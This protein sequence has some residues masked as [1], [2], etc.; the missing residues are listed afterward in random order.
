M[1]MDGSELIV[2]AQIEGDVSPGPCKITIEG[3]DGTTTP[4]WG[5][6]ADVGEWL[7]DGVLAVGNRVLTTQCDVMIPLPIGLYEVTVSRGVEYEAPSQAI[8]LT[9][10]EMG[11]VEPVLSRVVDS[12]GWACGDMHVHSGPSLDSDV[13]IDQRLVSAVAEGLDVLVPTDHDTRGEWSDPMV[14]VELDDRLGLAVGL[15]VSPD[16]WRNAFMVGHANAYPLPD[17]FQPSEFATPIPMAD[18]IDRL[19]PSLPDAVFQLNHPRLPTFAAFDFLGE[20]PIEGLIAHDDGT[21]RFQVLEVW[22]AHELDLGADVLAL[23]LADWYRLL[24]AGIHVVGV[25]N[26]DTHRLTFNMIGY[27]RTCARVADDRA[28]VDGE[29]FIDSVRLGHAFATSGPFV[30]VSI[31]DKSLFD[32]VDAGSPVRIDV[33][34]S[35]PSWAAANRVKL[36]QDGQVVDER[37]I[38]SLPGEASFEIAPVRDGWVIVLVEGPEPPSARVAG[39]HGPLRLPTFAFTN[40]IFLDVDGDGEIAP[41]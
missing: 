35:A 15:E 34:V 16:F 37:P 22:N 2:R 1:S 19:R 30:E 3:R 29:A 20:A 6:S 21:L 41:R 31:G 32:V 4:Q 23:V 5:M 17:T 28:P 18:L 25:G 13:P 10:G 12:S 8:E 39:T 38:A 11:R 33:R 27:P 14:E 9:E 24:N 36:V 7:A 26:T 40:P